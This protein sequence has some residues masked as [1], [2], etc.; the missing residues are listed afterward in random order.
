MV[1]LYETKII[2]TMENY[3]IWILTVLLFI[4]KLK[5]FINILHKMLKKYEISNYEVD[6]PL[7]KGMNKNILVLM[8]D[9]L[10]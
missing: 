1:S 9:E 7:E 10:G 2:K 4:L 3:V 8:K 5:T 6:R